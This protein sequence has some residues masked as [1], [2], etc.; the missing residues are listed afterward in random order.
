[1]SKL[2]F[3]RESVLGVADEIIPLL[4]MHYDEIAL[5]KDVI[6]L[7]PDWSRYVAMEETGNCHVFTMRE[8]G[9]LIGYGVFF[10]SQHIH[11]QKTKVAHNDILYLVPDCRRGLSAIKFIKFCEDEMKAIGVNKMTWHIKKANDWSAILHR[12]GYDTEEVVVGKVL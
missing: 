1:M 11:Y 9:V 5:H 6:K 8:C 10:T 12:Q 4:E 2:A 3:A 7:D